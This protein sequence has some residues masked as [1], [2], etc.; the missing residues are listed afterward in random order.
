M[1]E[2]PLK[3]S[4]V[5]PFYNEEKHLA[6]CIDSVLD[7]SYENYEV[8]LINDGS[9]DG[10]QEIAEF[11]SRKFE[12][13]KLINKINT[14]L[15][16]SRDEGVCV[17]SGEYVMFVDSDDTITQKCLSSLMSHAIQDNNVLS[18]IIV[19]GFTYVYSNKQTK[20]NVVYPNLIKG[21]IELL[22]DDFVDIYNS[23]V[24]NPIWNK[25]FRIEFLN[26]NKLK[27]NRGLKIFV[28]VP[29][30]Y[31]ALR[32]CKYIAIVPFQAYNYHVTISGMY[33]KLHSFNVY[34]ESLKMQYN[35]K[36]MFAENILNG[37]SFDLFK[38]KI[39]RIFL[40]G[41]IEAISKGLLSDSKSTEF[42]KNIDFVI[43]YT[44]NNNLQFSTE[45]LY[46]KALI[47][48]TKNRKSSLY[49]YVLWMLS[50]IPLKAKRFIKFVLEK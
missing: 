6:R 26:E 47:Y 1:Q 5:I 48:Y 23:N 29:F 2:K 32:L 31:D 34:F 40:Q 18:D 7:Q 13:V 20:I 15:C 43:N 9:N 27:V 25:L 17:A 37:A 22:E 30:T 24:L 41:L 16:S 21:K 8:L 42:Y 3:V 35:F 19:G 39:E 33:N 12:N 50:L 11:Y 14:G 38:N 46:E 36:I 4:V 45:N 49:I 44:R 10:S 28:D